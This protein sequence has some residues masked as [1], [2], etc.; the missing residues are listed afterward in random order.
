MKKLFTE[1][2]ISL[3]KLPASSWRMIYLTQAHVPKMFLLNFVWELGG[4]RRYE[5]RRNGGEGKNG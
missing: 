3:V 2:T 1:H 4:K 5:L